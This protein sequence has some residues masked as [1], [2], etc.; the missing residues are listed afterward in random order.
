MSYNRYHP[1]KTSQPQPSHQQDQTI[2]QNQWSSAQPQPSHQQQNQTTSQ[3]KWDYGTESASFKIGA[4]NFTP[5]TEEQHALEEF[6]KISTSYHQTAQVPLNE[7]LYQDNNIQNS[8]QGENVNLTTNPSNFLDK[9]I[10]TILATTT[11][12]Q[13][14][15]PQEEKGNYHII[16]ESLSDTG[17]ILSGIKVLSWKFENLMSD[18]DFE[19]LIDIFRNVD[20]LIDGKLLSKKEYLQRIQLIGLLIN[21]NW[22][23]KKP[24]MQVKVWRLMER[25]LAC[26][27]IKTV[28]KTV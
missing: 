10:E 19:N 9:D 20:R 28:N 14:D 15:I 1:Y 13:D 22:K 21:L 16:S 25:K 18:S 23:I 6:E 2:S 5:T 26:R 7:D 17:V 24:P 8:M 11:F 4:S 3:N 12:L 27:K